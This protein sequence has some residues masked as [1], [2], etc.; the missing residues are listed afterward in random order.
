MSKYVAFVRAINVAGHAS[1]K[2]NDLKEAF[3]AAGCKDVRTYIQSG[4]VVFNASEPDANGVFE[5]VRNR[6]RRLVT[7]EP[8]V[9]FRRL[10]EVRRVVRGNPFKDLSI[11]SDVK[12]YVAF[13]SRKPRNKPSFPFRAPKEALEV[14]GMKNLDVF[15][16]SRRKDNGFYGFP[17]N[18]IEKELGVLATSRNWSTV[19]KIAELADRETTC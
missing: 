12:L 14:I 2:M 19:N 18:F 9:M 11:G 17:N 1:V 16:V 15:I 4:N 8:T 3:A 5:S 7:G 10:Q 13:L 6:L